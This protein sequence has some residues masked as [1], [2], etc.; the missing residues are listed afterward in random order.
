MSAEAQ[1][2]PTNR[3]SPRTR[4][5]ATAVGGGRLVVQAWIASRGLIVC[6]A[7]LLAVTRHDPLT[8]QVS[9]W[10]V[11]HFVRL[12]EGGY[13]AEPKNQLMAFFPGLPLLLAGFERLGVPIALTGVL[14][15]AVG[16][17]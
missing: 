15:A 13:S 17:A 14:L 5:A 2:V 11:Q 7:L 1:A 16:S 3:R 8:A 9:N 4:E 12:A 10:D 6:V